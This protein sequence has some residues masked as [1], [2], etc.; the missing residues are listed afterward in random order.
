VARLNI[1]HHFIEEFRRRQVLGVVVI[2]VVAAWGLVEVADN[3]T[4]QGMFRIDPRLVL[5]AAIIGL[6]FALVAGWFYDI[7][8]QGV[9][10]TAP[11]KAKP[12]F[13]NTLGARD[14]AFIG[15]LVAAWLLTVYVA[16]S[17]HPADRSLALLPFEVRGNDP[18]SEV[19][20]SGIREDLYGRLGRIPML[21]I[22]ALDA[23][24]MVDI[25]QPV[26][27]IGRQL[28]AAF[29]LKATVE[30]IADR[31]HISVSL[32]DSSS[33]DSHWSE[34]YDR[35]LTTEALFQIRRDIAKSIAA[36]LLIELTDEQER[37]LDYKA[38]TS[39]AAWQ[40]YMLGKSQLRERAADSMVIAVREL[41]QAILLD[42]AFALAHAELAM[43]TALL[44]IYAGTDQNEVKVR[45]HAE[46]AVELD[47]DLPESHA[48]MRFTWDD[49]R[50]KH[51]RTA[52]ALNPSYA[53]A[54]A[55]LALELGLTGDHEGAFEENE[56]AARLDP[57][58]VPAN[59]NLIR[60][61]IL[62]RRIAEAKEH[63]DRFALFCD[64][65]AEHLEATI[66]SL[67][68]NWAE[69]I[70]GDLRLRSMNRD[71]PRP[72]S[73]LDDLTWQL[74]MVGLESEA[75]EMAFPENEQ[76]LMTFDWQEAATWI[77][78][79]YSGGDEPDWGLHSSVYIWSYIG[80]Y[81]RALRAVDEMLRNVPPGER[82]RE[83]TFANSYLA[84][85]FVAVLRAAGDEERA[86]KVIAELLTNAR[87][88]RDAGIH[89]SLWEESVDYQ[90]GVALYLSGERSRGAK[91][92][93]RAAQDGYWLPKPGKFQE[94]M[95]VEP[96]IK[97]ALKIQAN[98]Q[99]RE[100]NRLLNVVC[101]NN[102]FRSI[103]RP[104][105]ETCR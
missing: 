77:R 67:D 95:Y 74:A 23:A 76:L 104:M 58:S 91:L 61:L 34:A 17:P 31:I 71:G 42:P 9:F 11:L 93:A 43:A 28:N 100:R 70:L 4:V 66:A 78:S 32:I 18:E 81:G 20:A 22:G 15:G 56:K 38:T 98:R 88:Y 86:N 45:F 33:S 1:F 57:R 62:R 5:L 40:A 89:V 48:A 27:R 35:E 41:E 2:Y 96:E 84:E 39:L 19:F 102:P 97:E 25:T 79:K 7:R 60:G 73:V 87:H 14:V 6:P 80:D 26:D 72:W 21:R 90:E 83:V 82:F 92:I 99:A 36:N 52:I 3:D 85:C 65:C 29:L 64:W 37:D 10:R 8:K 53:D 54:H 47:P 13:N 103:W 75:R 55:W 59:Y 68:G 44:P 69:I 50:I 46:Q 12:S 105:P 16:Y 24:D 94:A 101:N 30:R 49:D 63:I 51:L